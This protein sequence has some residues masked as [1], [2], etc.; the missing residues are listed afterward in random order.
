MAEITVGG[1]KDVRLLA[2]IFHAEKLTVSGYDGSVQSCGK[3][4]KARQLR[5]GNNFS[6]E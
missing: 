1:T 2:G 5:D 6:E 3:R 4:K